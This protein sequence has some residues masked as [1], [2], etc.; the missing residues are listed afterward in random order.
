M[1]VLGCFK[2]LCFLTRYFWIFFWNFYIEFKKNTFFWEVEVNFFT[3]FEDFKNLLIKEMWNKIIENVKWILFSPISKWGMSHTEWFSKFP[4]VMKRKI[5]HITIK[6]EYIT[7][8]YRIRKRGLPFIK[9]SL[10][11]SLC[12]SNFKYFRSSKY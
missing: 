6:L 8:T 4:Y 12:L 9:I 10:K 1:K 5:I 2:I 3:C 11:I 7:V